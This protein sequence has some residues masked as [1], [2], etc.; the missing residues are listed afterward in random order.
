MDST[1]IL[2]CLLLESPEGGLN[3]PTV[4]LRNGRGSIHPNPRHSG[5]HRSPSQYQYEPVTASESSKTS[6]TTAIAL[7][8][9]S[10]EELRLEQIIQ[11]QTSKTREWA[12]RRSLWN[13][14][15]LS[16]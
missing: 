15:P 12:F 16:W 11:P 6:S 14:Y 13:V 3:K 8:K 10:E 7:H 9:T 1:W 4:R 2:D 5:L